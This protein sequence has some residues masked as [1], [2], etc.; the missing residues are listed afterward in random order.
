MARTF[1]QYGCAHDSSGSL[2]VVLSVGGVEV[3]NGSVTAD[4]DAHTPGETF[5]ENE[6][7]SFELDESVSGD[8]AWSITVNGTDES[9]NIFLGKLTC[10]NVRPNMTIPLEYFMDKIIAN[11]YDL[12][13]PFTA[14][15]QLYIDGQLGDSLTAGLRTKLQAG[16]SVPFDDGTT[17]MLAN[18][19]D[20]VDANVYY[21]VTKTLS[22]GQIDGEAYD[23]TVAEMWPSVN[24]ESTLTMTVN[25][26]VPTF[27]YDPPLVQ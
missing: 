22:N 6:L 19:Q 9:S 1:K 15:E 13:I 12:T 5:P 2:N 17:V 20:G 11:S 8:T 25:L 26:G 23:V 3:F 4:T 24:S 16:T 27:E 21:N 18:E 7:F 14:E 10:N